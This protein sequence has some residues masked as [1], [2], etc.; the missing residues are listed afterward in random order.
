MT[1]C[2]S[3]KIKLSNLQLKELNSGTKHSTEVTLRIPLNMAGNFNDE[4]SF[5]YKLLITD[6][7][8]IVIVC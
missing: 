5:P 6:R 1:H 4:T 2:N 7:Q 8:L 3:V